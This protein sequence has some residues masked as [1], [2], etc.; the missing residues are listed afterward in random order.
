M[1]RQRATNRR[2]LIDVPVEIQ[3]EDAMELEKVKEAMVYSSEKTKVERK[4][5]EDMESMSSIDEGMDTEALLI[6]EILISLNWSTVSL[7]LPTI[8]KSKKTEEYLV[9]ML[10]KHLAT[11]E[12]EGHNGV[13]IESFE[14]CR[15]QKAILE[16]PYIEMTR[17]IKPLYVRVH[18]N[19]KSVTKVLINNGSS[20]NVMPLRML[21]ALERNISDLIEIEVTVSAFTREVSK[22]LAILPIDITIGNK[23]ALSTFFVIDS[24]TNYNILL[25]RDWIHANWCVSSSFHQFLLFGKGNE[26]EVVRA[27]K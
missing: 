5:I 10:G 11:E 14:E 3:K 2:H 24:T 6:G 8:F 15:P 20:V 12:D 17:H 1:Q 16:K 19:G 13:T 21:R 26:V 4:V 27:N 22:T 25:G 9:K 18:L 23:T 7:T